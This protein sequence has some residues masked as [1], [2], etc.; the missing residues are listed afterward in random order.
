MA[1][2]AFANCRDQIRSCFCPGPAVGKSSHALQVHATNQ[3]RYCFD[4][5]TVV[6]IG[7]HVRVLSLLFLQLLQQVFQLYQN[8]CTFLQACFLLLGIFAS[9]VGSFSFPHLV[10]SMRLLLLLPMQLLHM[11]CSTPNQLFF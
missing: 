3:Q 10:C 9:C 8:L 6:C 7:V 1:Q 11:R 2:R 5:L 4:C